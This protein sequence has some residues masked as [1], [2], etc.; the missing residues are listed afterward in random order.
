MMEL[1]EKYMSTKQVKCA[2]KV[3]GCDVMHLRE[4]GKVKFIKK[5]NAFLY[6]RS[7]VEKLV[8]DKSK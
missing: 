5:G 3:S 1:Q 7:D 6:L 8:K 2:L 4:A